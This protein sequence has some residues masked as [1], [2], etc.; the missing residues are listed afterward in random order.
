MIDVFPAQVSVRLPQA[1]TFVGDSA[2]QD[3]L[4]LAKMALPMSVSYLG[5]DAFRNCRSLV[6]V[7]LPESLTRLRESRGWKRQLVE[8]IWGGVF[9]APGLE[10]LFSMQEC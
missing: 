9:L 7:T 4:S 1:L 10:H 6:S 2:F 3:C 8:A 5:T